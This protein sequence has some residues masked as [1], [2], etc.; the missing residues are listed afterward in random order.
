MV[1]ESTKRRFKKGIKKT[2]TFI[3]KRKKKLKKL[4]NKKPILKPSRK[5]GFGIL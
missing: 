2:K 3:K 4:A 1:F 5:K